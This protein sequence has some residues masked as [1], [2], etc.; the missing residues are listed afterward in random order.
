MAFKL[1]VT[2]KKIKIV[3]SGLGRK[4]KTYEKVRRYLAQKA[5]IEENE[6]TV[7]QFRARCGTEKGVCV[8]NA[9]GKVADMIKKIEKQFHNW[10]VALFSMQAQLVECSGSEFEKGPIGGSEQSPINVTITYSDATLRSPPSR[11]LLKTKLKDKFK[12]SKVRRQL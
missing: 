2:E 1:E 11:D 6:L 10:K 4:I 12:K 8:L 9:I 3:V 5:G 7:E